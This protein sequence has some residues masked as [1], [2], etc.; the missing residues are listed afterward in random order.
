M[1]KPVVECRHYHRRAAS[2]WKACSTR[3]AMF[4]GYTSQT[5]WKIGPPIT[6]EGARM[7][8][9]V[10]HRPRRDPSLAE[11]RELSHALER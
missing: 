2:W 7:G 4:P 6:F 9:P 11:P 10:L 5:D 1:Q 3:G 8:G